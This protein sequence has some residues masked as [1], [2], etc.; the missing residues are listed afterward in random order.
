MHLDMKYLANR[1]ANHQVL[2]WK[3]ILSDFCAKL[4]S[5]TQ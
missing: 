3:E 1:K 2:N 5:L 4:L